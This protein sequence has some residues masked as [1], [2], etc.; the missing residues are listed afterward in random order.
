MTVYTVDEFK[1]SFL[2]NPIHSPQKHDSA[3]LPPGAVTKHSMFRGLASPCHL[4]LV[5]AHGSA[6][7]FTQTDS[8]EGLA[9]G[10]TLV[11]AF[12]DSSITAECIVR[13]R[14]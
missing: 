9:R 3:A 10:P 14:G 12:V 8:S 1:T 5:H 2:L 11:T 6:C 7:S 4:C 13:R